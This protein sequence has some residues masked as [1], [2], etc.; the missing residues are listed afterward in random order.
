[1]YKGRI[2]RPQADRINRFNAFLSIQE[3]IEG[4][5]T[6]YE[7]RK[8]TGQVST[9]YFWSLVKTIDGRKVTVVIRQL[10]NGPKHFFS[11]IRGKIK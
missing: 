9:A 8:S 2:L 1:M 3:I 7:Y 11:I 6:F 5:E 4:S 10:D